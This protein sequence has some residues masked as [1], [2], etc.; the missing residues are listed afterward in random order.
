MRQNV[1]VG[2]V[3]ALA[4]LCLGQVFAQ[5]K[6]A[7]NFSR[8][9]SRIATVKGEIKVAGAK[10]Q[11]FSA[12]KC[13]QIAIEAAS[14]SETPPVG[15]PKWERHARATG[16]WA[17]GSCSYQIAVPPDQKF[18]VRL[19]AGMKAVPCGGYDAVTSTPS[20]TGWISVS[21][22]GV[23]TEDFKLDSVACV[24]LK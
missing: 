11:G 16:S 6:P 3:S 7:E 20:E 19:L 14:E 15:V 23:K 1:L 17:S 22:G 2:I 18:H 4:L 21:P 5:K 13:P 24:P 8:P 10:T 9:I 12:L